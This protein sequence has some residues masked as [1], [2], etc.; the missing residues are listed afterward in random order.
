[1]RRAVRGSTT[2]R[3]RLTFVSG[4]WPSGNPRMYVRR[5]GQK[6]TPL[7]DL[8]PQD[9]RFLAA[10]AAILGGD[11]P[12]K[13]PVISGTIAAGIIA[14]MRS[15]KYLGVSE[16]TRRVWRRGLDDMRSRYGAGRAA[17]LTARHIRQDLDRLTPNPA[18]QRLK[19]WRALCAWWLERDL[20]D[21]DPAV[22][23]K[24]R[25]APASDGHT[26]WTDGDVGTF[27]AFWPLESPER[28]AMEL[29][30]WVGS[31]MS[32]ACRHSEAQIGRDGWLTYT[33]QKT[34]TICA[35]PIRTAAPGWSDPATLAHLQA[36]IDARPTRH[37]AFMVTG[38]GKPR[39][40]KAASSWFARA[41]RQAGIESGKSAHGLRKYRSILMTENGAGK[42]QRMAWLGHETESEASR[43]SKGADRK[44]IIA[45]TQNA[46][47]GDQVSNLSEK[48]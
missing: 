32:D 24:A 34:G 22:T 11:A 38:Y 9:P 15:D 6:N 39:S 30:Q 16:N 21:T 41:A 5:K 19:I 10:Y 27:R 47:S 36:A 20:I 35:V 3:L 40:V 42:D 46:N 25:K 13:Q 29:L 28:L 4:S 37:M 7:P 48:A 17:H 31:R 23:V 44:R 2:V 14:F 12:V 33:Q 18:N 1:M 43:Y 45:G 8:P 26:P